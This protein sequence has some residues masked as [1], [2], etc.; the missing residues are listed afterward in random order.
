MQSERSAIWPTYQ[1]AIHRTVEHPD[2]A[3]IVATVSRAEC[4]TECAPFKSTVRRAH[5]QSER[6]ANRPTY[7]CPFYGIFE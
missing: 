7:K 3:A 2:S 1:R 5:V 4:S 6:S